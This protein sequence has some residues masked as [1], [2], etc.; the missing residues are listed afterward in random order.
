MEENVIN[1]LGA[2]ERQRARKWYRWLWLSPLLTIPTLII[3]FAAYDKYIYDLVC[4]QGWQNCDYIIAYRLQG[5][6]AVGFSALWHLV[7][8][9]PTRDRESAFVCWHGRQAIV[10]A[11]LRTAVPLIFL[12]IFGLEGIAFTSI[13]ILISIWL[14]GTLWGQRQAARG[15]CSLARWSGRTNILPGPPP[16]VEA[17]HVVEQSNQELVDIVRFSCDPEK[18]QAALDQLSE[19]GLVENL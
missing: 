3:L 11:G 12:V 13:L 16:K 5:L 15:D 9:I 8:L 1:D 18:R 7:L 19:R 14:F 2:I 6:I 10:L 4:P 17:D